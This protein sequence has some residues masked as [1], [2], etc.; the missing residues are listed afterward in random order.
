MVSTIFQKK[1]K[2]HELKTS[3]CRNFDRAQIAIN[4]NKHKGVVNKFADRLSIVRMKSLFFFTLK[5]TKKTVFHVSTILQTFLQTWRAKFFIVQPIFTS[6][7][8]KKFENTILETDFSF[9]KVFGNKWKTFIF[10]SFFIHFLHCWN[11]LLFQWFTNIWAFSNR[12]FNEFFIIFDQKRVIFCQKLTIT[13]H[14]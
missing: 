3:T 10:L 7:F 6:C 13:H 2:E 11:W 4:K 9:Q 1:L 12:I 8:C 5:M 14:F